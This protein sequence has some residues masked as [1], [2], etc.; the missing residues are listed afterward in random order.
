MLFDRLNVDLSKEV[1]SSRLFVLIFIRIQPKKGQHG[2][3]Y[4]NKGRGTSYSIMDSIKTKERGNME[5]KGGARAI[6]L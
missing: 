3:T 2:L 6:Q 5:I 1:H 4:G